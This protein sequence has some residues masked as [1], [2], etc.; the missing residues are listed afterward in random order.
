MLNKNVQYNS[1]LKEVA[2][3]QEMRKISTGGI[4]RKKIKICADFVS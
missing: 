4:Q 3:Q 2:V 1:M